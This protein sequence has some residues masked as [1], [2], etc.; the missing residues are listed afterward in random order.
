[1]EQ[2]E[3]QPGRGGSAAPAIR[4]PRELGK[5]KKKGFF[6]PGACFCSARVGLMVAL[7][8]ALNVTLNTEK[9]FG[10]LTNVDEYQE[11]DFGDVF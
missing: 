10:T 6:D 1:M 2:Q 11:I 5:K 4:R 3:L 8:C 7:D 9:D